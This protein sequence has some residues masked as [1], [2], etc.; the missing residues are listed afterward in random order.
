[1]R[2]INQYNKISNY[3]TPPGSYDGAVKVKNK[4][5]RVRELNRID[6][7]GWQRWMGPPSSAI[8]KCMKE[9]KSI[10]A[11]Q[12]FPKRAITGFRTIGPKNSYTCE[13]CG[14]FEEYRPRCNKCEEEF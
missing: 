10:R 6:K 7:T 3:Y 2:L 12:R 8:E 9:T 13:F 14:T 5:I 4:W 1:M 11:D